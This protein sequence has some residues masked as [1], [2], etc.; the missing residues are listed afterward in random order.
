[1][2]LVSGSS[3]YYNIKK[4]AESLYRRAVNA[5]SIDERRLIAKQGKELADRL[6]EKY[7]FEDK[8]VKYIIEQFYLQRLE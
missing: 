6:L 8:E 5:S 2:G 1:M 4:H 7:G 3:D